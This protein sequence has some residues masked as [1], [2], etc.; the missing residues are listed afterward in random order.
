MEL[1]GR[2]AIVTGGGTGVGRAT[3]HLLA[4]QGCDVLVN[5]SRSKAGAEETAER[6]RG[7]SGYRD[8]REKCG[9]A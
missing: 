6:D 7:C 1:E 9:T 2:A 4:D 5:Y 3:A 8:H